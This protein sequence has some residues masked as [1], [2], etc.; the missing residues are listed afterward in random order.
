M[1]FFKNGNYEI[2]SVAFIFCIKYSKVCYINSNQAVFW[3]GED[4]MIEIIE[5]KV[6]KG[7]ITFHFIPNK[8]FKTVNIV[9]KCKSPLDRSTITKRAL[10]R[11]VLEQG[12][13]QYPTEKALMLKLDELY[14]AVLT[15]ASMKKGNEH[16]LHFQM[17]VANQRFIENESTI[18]EEALHLFHE[19]IFEPNR[20]ATGFNDQIVTREKET[21]KSKIESIYDDKV[22]FANQ[23]LIDHMCKD[24]KFSIHTNGYEEDL[25]SINGENLSTYYDTVLASDEMDLYV[26]G[27]IDVEEIE[28][29]VTNVFTRPNHHK[30]EILSADDVRTRSDVQ[31]IV[32]TQAIQ[33]A[34]LHLGY[35]TNCTYKD[36]D[37]AALQVF[38]GLYGGFPNSKLFL[39]VREKHSL[40]YY[41][42]SR[43][44]SHK[45]LLLVFSGIEPTDYEKAK[46]IIDDQFALMQ[47]GNF[48]EQ[49]VE[50]TKELIVSELK[51]TLDSPYGIIE[52]LYQQVVGDKP[53][54]PKTL[55]EKIGQIS[56]PDVEAIAKKIELD[57]VYLLT[58]EQGG[59][60]HG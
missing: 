51:E 36:E 26:L 20:D 2:Y 24:E 59:D 60:V 17:E 29:Q 16:I 45:G 14:G 52:L 30:Q 23:R 7:G 10:L 22:S 47:A 3:K 18:M 46:T 49:E 11:Y 44:E 57:T 9:L 13:K 4:V 21:L 27:D 15:L 6:N 8:K 38:N 5:K 58:K 34:K 55:I 35:R 25:N 40:A 39:N 37:Y 53:L 1:S 42:A 28:T 32:E 41:A 33:Q 56:K 31:D 43:I 12:T 19:I 48:T 54:S 50:E